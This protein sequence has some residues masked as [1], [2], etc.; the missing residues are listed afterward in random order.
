M[1]AV[2]PDSFI[3]HTMLTLCRLLHVKAPITHDLLRACGIG[4]QK[5]LLLY[6]AT[7]TFLLLEIGDKTDLA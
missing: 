7:D 1:G 3:V 5:A 4:I 6:L 2:I